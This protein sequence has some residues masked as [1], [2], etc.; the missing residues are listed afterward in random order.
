M[1]TVGRHARVGPVLQRNAHRA[2]AHLQRLVVDMVAVEDQRQ[3]LALACRLAL[4]VDELRRMRD[5]LEDDDEL[6][7]QLERKDRLFARR[8]FDVVQ[9]EVSTISS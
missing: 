9:R 4:H 7:R 2:R 8:Q 6:G 1:M 3:A 5:R